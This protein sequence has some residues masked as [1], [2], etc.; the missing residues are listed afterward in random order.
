MRHGYKTWAENVAVEQRKLLHLTANA[1]LP[2][3]SLASRLEI[4]VI[5]PSQ[6]PGITQ[7]ILSRLLRIDSDSWSAVTLKRNGCTLIIHNPTHSPRR[8]ESDLMHE[9]A[10][11]I[12][13][14]EPSRVVQIDSSFPALRTYDPIQEEEAGW[15][16]GCLQ[17]PRPALLW[18]IQR[19]M[20]DQMIESHF[21][22]SPDIVRFRRQMTG[23]DRQMSK[24]R[25]NY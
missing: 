9:L 24:R 4:A 14:H 5:G 12:C 22:A 17:L 7:E 16:G 19:G 21:S 1:P 10:H 25:M 13:Q 6:I 8:Q 11:L 15:L 3:R 20:N 2:A 18:A 23:V